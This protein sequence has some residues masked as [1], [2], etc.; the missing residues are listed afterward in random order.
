MKPT[1][2]KLLDDLEALYSNFTA[3]SC[4]Q[5]GSLYDDNIVFEDPFHQIKG[6]AEIKRYFLTLADNL[7]Y[8]HFKFTK[9]IHDETSALITWVM[10]FSH[11]KIA[12]GI[13]QSLEGCSHIEFN[14]KITKHRDYFDSVQMLYSHIPVLKNLINF[15]KQRAT[16]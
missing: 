14:Q 9:V 13:K 2:N 6:I 4:Q 10:Y 8:C 16:Q 3:E 5:L 12:G 7:N 15:V 1:T 11:P